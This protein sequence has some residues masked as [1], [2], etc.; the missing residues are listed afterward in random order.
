MNNLTSI[1][2]PKKYQNRIAEIYQDIDG[3]W[4][5]L[6]GGWY[7]DD[8]SLHVIHED[9]QADILR[10]IRETKP[11]DCERCRNYYKEDANV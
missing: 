6:S 10:C 7:W 4:C 11:C 9:T 2:V 8:W 5:E 1:R 3:Y